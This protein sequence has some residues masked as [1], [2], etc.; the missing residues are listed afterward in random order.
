M[1]VIQTT[2]A[3]YDLAEKAL[4]CLDTSGK[5]HTIPHDKEIVVTMEGLRTTITMAAHYLSIYLSR[6]CIIERIAFAEEE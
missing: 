6:G 5:R 1:T 2:D 3:W 4:L